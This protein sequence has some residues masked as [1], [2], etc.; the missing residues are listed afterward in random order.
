MTKGIPLG[1]SEREV[2]FG[3]VEWAITRNIFHR[4]TQWLDGRSGQSIT[5]AK[6][7]LLDKIDNLTRAT[8]Y[9]PF[10]GK[11]EK[12]FGDGAHLRH[13]RFSLFEFKATLTL[14][15]WGREALPEAGGKP[16]KDRLTHSQALTR[17]EQEKGRRYIEPSAT[18]HFL[19]GMLD[20]EIKF[21]SYW[22]FIFNK[23]I[24]A[25]GLESLETNSLGAT[26]EEFLEYLDVLESCQRSEGGSGNFSDW[27]TVV[28][29]HNRKLKMLA[30]MTVKQALEYKQELNKTIARKNPYQVG[31][32]SA[33][34]PK[35]GASNG[36]LLEGPETPSSRHGREAMAK[37][38]AARGPKP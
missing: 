15:E 26:L 13:D 28:L 37:D 34:D 9:I 29:V 14:G 18:F 5:I 10:A 4:A 21:T 31:R 30:A 16:A 12:W 17:R 27:H 7:D 3:F 2:E 22:P 35:A 1:I 6:N 20:G 23:R 32:E 33:R 19:A 38:N 8:A 36:G 25:E 11:R 24:N